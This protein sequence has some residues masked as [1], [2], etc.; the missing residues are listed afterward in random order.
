MPR[1][2]EQSWLRRRLAQ[3]GRALDPGADDRRALLLRLKDLRARDEEYQVRDD[4]RLKRIESA[5]GLIADAVGDGQRQLA[6]LR[7]LT[8]RQ[9]AATVRLAE[10]LHIEQMGGAA[11]RKVEARLARLARTRLPIIVGPWSGEVGFELLYWVPFLQWACRAYSLSPDRLVVISRGGVAGWYRHVARHYADALDFLTPEMFRQAASDRLKQWRVRRFDRRLIRQV[12]RTRGLRQAHV[13]HPSLMYALFNS[14]WSDWPSTREID[15]FTRFVPLAPPPGGSTD[16]ALPASFVAVRFYFSD[17]FPDTPANRSLAAR[18]VRGLAAHTDVVL[19]NNDLQIDDHHDFTPEASGRVHHLQAAMRPENNLAVQTAA[20]ARAKAFVGT[21]GGFSYLAPLYGVPSVAFYAE[22]TFEQRHLELAQRAFDRIGHARLTA[23][24][25]R[26]APPLAAALAGLAPEGSRSDVQPAD[27]RL[28]LEPLEWGERF[29]RLHERERAIAADKAVVTSLRDA[30]A[31]EALEELRPG[32]DGAI[33]KH[34]VQELPARR[35]RTV[36]THAT[37]T[38]RTR[39]IRSLVESVGGPLD[40]TADRPF[41]TGFD[42]RVVEI[43]LALR[44]A[45]LDVPGRVLDAG[46]ALNVPVVRQLHPKVAAHLTHFTLPGSDEPIWRGDPNVT[47]RFGDLR[48]LPFEPASFDRIVCVSTLEHVGMDTT[49]FGAARAP[50]T[51]E[52]AT[53]AV[54]ELVRVLATGGTLLLTVPYGCAADRGWYRVFDARALDELLQPAAGNAVERR[55][56]YYDK[57]WVES[58]PEV[59]D[60]AREADGDIIAGV[61]IVQVRKP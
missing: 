51:P 31:I 38:L 29:E 48:A 3:L 50:G 58:G 8:R 43:P 28:S 14:Y 12:M 30:L 27:L 9:Q 52:T 46:S 17:C 25:I 7:G 39:E 33:L 6:E 26:Q 2:S 42:E 13:L 59:P 61:A 4:R 21:Y 54:A 19:L 20:I 16:L 49:R 53:A 56:F 15:R 35:M 36:L 44:V 32:W 22:K 57:G 41:G 45:A 60:A 23:I 37:E 47:Y 34:R 11:Q 10:Q 18:I 24:D 55:F 5:V 40:A 1:P